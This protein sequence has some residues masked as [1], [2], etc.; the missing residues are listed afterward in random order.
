M[1]CRNCGIQL[2][3]GSLFCNK[4]GVR[5][6]QDKVDLFSAGHTES[7]AN[8]KVETKRFMNGFEFD[9]DAVFLSIVSIII[10]I[11]SLFLPIF[12][13]R[14]GGTE[15][16]TLKLT[17]SAPAYSGEWLDNICSTLHISLVVIIA[18]M[19]LIIFLEVLKERFFGMF[20]A[21]VLIGTVAVSWIKIASDWR[22]YL[23]GGVVEPAAGGII[24]MIFIGLLFV[25]TLFLWLDNVFGT[26]KSAFGALFKRQK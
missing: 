15:Y 11:I 12:S 9:Q 13:F 23:Q 19:L 22:E 7:N 24:L 1:F 6:Q 16:G 3:E 21:L 26:V 5:C 10:L 17:E 25:H 4:C 20:C 14:A 8:T 2:P 18:L